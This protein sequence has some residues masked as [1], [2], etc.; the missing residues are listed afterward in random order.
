MD[1]KRED[2]TP[3]P[4]IKG[5]GIGY[6]TTTDVYLCFCFQIYYD[7]DMYAAYRGDQTVYIE[8]SLD[9]VLMAVVHSVCPFTSTWRFIFMHHFSYFF[10]I[11]VFYRGGSIIPRKDR[12]RRSSYLSRND[13]YTLVVAL[14]R[15]VRNQ[16]TN[17]RL[18]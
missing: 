8:A 11:P 6:T 12:I 2:R 14:D 13:P 17:I 18:S 10:Q 5:H 7:Y 16:Q 9:K 15:R 1:H 4:T 3:P